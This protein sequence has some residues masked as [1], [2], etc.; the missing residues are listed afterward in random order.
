[1]TKAR[2]ATLLLSL[3]ALLA[4]CGEAAPSSGD[5]VIEFTA[6]N[7]T[8]VPRP[9]EFIRL[10][11]DIP[12]GALAGVE[13][14]TSLVFRV[15]NGQ[16]EE[17][18]SQ[19]LE[20]GPA[21]EQGNAAFH[22]E[23]VFQDGFSPGETKSYE[24]RFDEASTLSLSPIEV[25]DLR[26]EGIDDRLL[27]R[28]GSYSF[29]I[30]HELERLDYGWG[31]ALMKDMYVRLEGAEQWAKLMPLSH[32][33][34]NTAEHRE[35]FLR[36]DACEPLFLISAGMPPEVS[37]RSGPLLASITLAYRGQVQALCP[38][39]EKGLDPPQPT[40]LYRAEVVLTF[41]RDLPRVDART[42]VV[43]AEGFYN[44]SGF[45]LGGV[46]TELARPRVLFG[47]PE[48]TVLQGALWADT[49]EGSDRTEFMQVED[50]RFVFRRAAS[51]DA[52][53]PFTVLSQSE[54]FLDYYV[55]EGKSGRGV[56]AYFPDF[57]R[58][59]YQNT[60][61]EGLEIIPVNM[62]GAGPSVPVMVANPI[63]LSQTHLG[64][65][66]DVWAPIAPGNYT[67]R[68]TALLDVPFD[69]EA[70][71]MYDA[72][73]EQLRVPMA[74]NVAADSALPAAVSTASA[75]RPVPASST[76]APT[77]TLGPTPAPAYCAPSR[78]SSPARPLPEGSL[79]PLLANEFTHFDSDG[80][81]VMDNRD[82]ADW[83]D[84]QTE[85]FA[86]PGPFSLAVAFEG[87]PNIEPLFLDGNPRGSTWSEGEVIYLGENAMRVFD[88]QPGGGFDWHFLGGGPGRMSVEFYFG[89]PC[90]RHIRVSSGGKLLD[91]DLEDPGG[92]T[93]FEN[94]LFPDGVVSFRL[95]APNGSW[96]KVTELTIKFE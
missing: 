23:I 76:P 59:A 58:L 18:P 45:A 35:E 1:V 5:L 56:F 64:N 78:L 80:A 48:H 77:A 96:V 54:T 10:S 73:A 38:P 68:L 15:V 49:N 70:G 40:D 86:V 34:F 11:L 17:V 27:V 81:L 2:A 57:Q 4:S 6:T 12:T 75:T 84:S 33:Y 52:A 69:P 13:G 14:K 89:E 83:A 16:E 55:V 22:L 44:H 30:G 20:S 8:N 72:A 9:A 61:N 24:L 60:R 53:S 79:L 47:V 63:I 65:V 51:R 41:Y 32:I 29:A 88:G 93:V 28:S 71:A 31:A 25:E 87:S 19:V 7:T 85:F 62:V 50:G 82:G 94:G 21:G 66:G 91:L 67:Y 92:V 74:V 36:S 46:E 3:F 43:L 39:H 90:A 95:Q 42:E 26:T 37:I